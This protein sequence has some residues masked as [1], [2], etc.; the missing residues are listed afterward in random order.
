MAHDS[1]GTHNEPQY[2]ETGVPADAADLTE[3]AAYAATVGNRRVDA[4]T[5]RTG[6]AGSGLWEGLEFYETD[7][8]LTY[9]Y[10]SNA[11]VNLGLVKTSGAFTPTGIYG[12]GTPAPALVNMAG[13]V[14]MSGI[15]TSSNATFVAGTTYTLGTIP[16]TFA[17]AGNQQFACT[18]NA[19]AVA[20]LTVFTTG[21]VTI[22]LNVGF[23][24]ALSLSLSGCIWTAPGV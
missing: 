5:V 6:L 24:G 23:T 14:S 13:R 16:T 18:A 4:S 20:Q 7:T 1:L 15:I 12:F 9:R 10:H 2:S 11:W 22:V 8:Y 17:P 3:V 19:T 21:N